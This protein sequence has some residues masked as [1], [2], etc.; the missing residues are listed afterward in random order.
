MAEFIGK[1]LGVFLLTW[2]W[3]FVHPIV[4]SL[5]YGWTWYQVTLEQEFFNRHN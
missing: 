5:M 1:I 2:V 4:F 3:L